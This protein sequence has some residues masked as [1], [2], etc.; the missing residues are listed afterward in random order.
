MQ[1]ISKPETTAESIL[2][3]SGVEAKP[4]RAVGDS[5]KQR[6]RLSRFLGGLSQAMKEIWTAEPY[7]RNETAR[8]T[9]YDYIHVRGIF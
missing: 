1:S 2:C 8:K 3:S 5:E 6:G 4:M 9:P 7:Y